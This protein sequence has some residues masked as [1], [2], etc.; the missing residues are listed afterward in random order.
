MALLKNLSIGK[1]LG[2][3]FGLVLILTSILAIVS[4][5]RN[6]EGERKHGR[7]RDQLAAQR[8]SSRHDCL[9]CLPRSE[10]SNWPTCCR[11]TKL[12][13]QHSQTGMS[14]NLDAL[15]EDIKEYEPMISSDEERGLV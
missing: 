9:R 15:S 7:H 8:E 13:E 14:N 3:G 11:R 10:D 6:I 2:I 1:K 4:D 5:L 12:S